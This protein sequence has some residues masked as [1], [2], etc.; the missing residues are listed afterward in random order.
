MSYDI[1]ETLV[2][3]A[4]KDI[5]PASIVQLEGETQFTRYLPLEIHKSVSPKFEA[6]KRYIK[7]FDRCAKRIQDDFILC[8]YF[9][10][11]IKREGLYRYC[12]EEG[13]QGY[14]NFYTF[15]E[16][17]LGV[18][19]TTAKRLIAINEHFC[20]NEAT[21][22]EAYQKYGA[23]KLAVMAT[24]KNG[25]EGKLQPSVTARQL[26][27][28]RKYYTL[29]EWNV[30]LDTTWRE[31]L[32]KFEEEQERDRL[33]KS[34]RLIERKFEAVK[35]ANKPKGLI[36][37]PYKTYTRFFDETLR[38]VAGLRSEKA[39]KFTPI[40]KELEEVLKRLQGEVLKMQ[41]NDMLDGL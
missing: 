12:I 37:D 4:K 24:F 13:L 31:D 10:N 29:H 8:G 38:T 27:K 11:L 34:T 30:K 15:C 16:D 40:V 28:L 19:T 23:S 39:T 32:K 18:A 14:T 25:L 3:K 6:L 9:L 36:S 21:L 26:D 2:A 22:P 35:E 17:V 1:I 7:D 5:Q 20:K 33:L 41:S